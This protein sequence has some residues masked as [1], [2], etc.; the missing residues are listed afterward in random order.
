MA[1]LSLKEK[2]QPALFDRLIDEER[3]ITRF[4][5]R[6]RAERL[7]ELKLSPRDLLGILASQ[8]LK[9][10]EDEQTDAVAELYT[11][12]FFAAAGAANPAQL[13]ALLLK[14]PGAPQGVALQSICEIE[15]RT[16]LNGQIEH[17]DKGVISMRRLR[18]CVQ[19]DLGWLLN[20]ASL[21]V[22]EDLSRY[23]YVAKSVLNYGMPSFAG[24]T[25]SS[26]EPKVAAQRIRDVINIYEPRL[27]RVQVIPEQTTTPDEMTLSFRIEAD[28]WG[29]PV[30]QHLVLRT[31]IDIESGD[32]RVT[33]AG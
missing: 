28:L 30:A 4:Q 13:K 32:V 29:Q 26:I 25:V 16:E 5:I 21:D 1:E 22:N 27:S 31:S 19:R 23:P 24:R 18:E 33:E 17:S 8:G 12:K 20:S 6:V 9:V 7:Q 10:E 11:W 15:S 14:P 2:L 3:Y